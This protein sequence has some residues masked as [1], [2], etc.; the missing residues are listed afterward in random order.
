MED[1]DSLK[2]SFDQM[3]MKTEIKCKHSVEVLTTC[4]DLESLLGWNYWIPQIPY[5]PFDPSWAIKIIP[6]CNGAMVRFH[7]H[8][9]E[10]NWVSVYL[11]CHDILG[12]MHMLGDP[13]PYWEVYPYDESIFR[14]LMQDV[15]ELLKAIAHALA[16][17]PKE[18]D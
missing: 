8:D 2:I 1:L 13:V 10:G 7:V 3:R 16:N 5:I 12:S 9:K 17:P 6:P 11:D 15:D 18:K 14:V 4:G